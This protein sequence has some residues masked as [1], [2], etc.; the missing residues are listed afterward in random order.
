MIHARWQT[1]RMSIC[2]VLIVGMLAETGRALL[3]P[4]VSKH[5]LDKEKA[6]SVI[7]PA[8]IPLTHWHLF[9]EQSLKSRENQSLGY[10]YQYRNAKNEQ[11]DIQ[12]RYEQY[13]EGNIN[14]LFMVYDIA[15][16]ASTNILIKQTPQGDAYGLMLYDGR[17]Y[18]SAC[19]NPIGHSTATAEQFAKNKY[20]YGLDPLRTLGWIAGLND[21]IDT[22]CFWTAISTPVSSSADKPV[23]EAK[24]QMLEAVWAEWYPWWRS[25][26]PSITPSA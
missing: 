23:I 26:L 12:V 15:P 20:Q 10:L 3:M 24:F 6:N 11:I 19:I 22:R 1:I 14:R 16:P 7:L 4:S 2:A 25:R 9:K 17:A 18:L 8:Q 13:A 21:L 5:I